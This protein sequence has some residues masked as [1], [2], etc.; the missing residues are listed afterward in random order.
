MAIIKKNDYL[1]FH[2]YLKKNKVKILKKHKKNFLFN[3]IKT[4]KNLKILLNKYH[5]LNYSTNDWEIIIGPWLFST[6]NIFF[7][8]NSC[9]FKKKRLINKKN[10]KDLKIYTTVPFDFDDFYNHISKY[11]FF[12]KHFFYIDNYKFNLAYKKIIMIK[13]FFKFY[14][15]KNFW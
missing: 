4:L 2:K 14:Y 9:N 5:N 13:K 1:I 6:L 8:Y 12:I 15:Q 3:Y 10:I 11:E 7:F